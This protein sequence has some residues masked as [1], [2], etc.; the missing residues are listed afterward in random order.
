MVR[1]QPTVEMCL[2]LS[3]I[4]IQAHTAFPGGVGLL[5]CVQKKQRPPAQTPATTI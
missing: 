1:E 2:K 5:F 4:I 3:R